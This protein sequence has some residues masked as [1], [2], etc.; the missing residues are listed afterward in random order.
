MHLILSAFGSYGDVLPMV[1]LGASARAR[2][3]RVSVIVNP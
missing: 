3:H 1:G 2:G